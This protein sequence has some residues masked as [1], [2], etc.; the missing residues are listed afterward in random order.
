MRACHLGAPITSPPF[1]EDVL[2]MIATGWTWETLMETP[3]RVVDET[4]AYL[5]VRGQYENSIARQHHG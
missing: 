4:L 5:H 3:Q 2:A 1:S